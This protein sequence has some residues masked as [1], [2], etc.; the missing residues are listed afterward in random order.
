[1]NQEIE[2]AFSLSILIWGGG[3]GRGDN[4]LLH[5]VSIQED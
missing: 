5:L 2:L 1:M 4:Y 3:G